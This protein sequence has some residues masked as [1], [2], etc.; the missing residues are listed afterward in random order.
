M[1]APHCALLH[2]RVQV[3]SVMDYGC[4]VTI[5]EGIEALVHVSEMAEERV[6]KPDAVVK[7]GQDV[8]VCARVPP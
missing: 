7:V 6:S 3:A 2:D 5:G 1:R 8:Q 4:F